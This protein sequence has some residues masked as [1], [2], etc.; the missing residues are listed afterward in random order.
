MVRS[1]AAVNAAAAS[2]DYKAP[3]RDC[4]GKAWGLGLGF[5]VLSI[6]APILQLGSSAQV[7]GKVEKRSMALEEARSFGFRV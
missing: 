6:E 2:R 5:S 4:R 3:E 1:A 7:P